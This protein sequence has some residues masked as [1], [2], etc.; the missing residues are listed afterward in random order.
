MGNWH[1][2]LGVRSMSMDLLRPAPSRPSLRGWAKLEEGWE[3]KAKKK[4]VTAKRQTRIKPGN[5]T[6]IPTPPPQPVCAG[7]PTGRDLQGGAAVS[8]SRQGRKKAT[9]R[10]KLSNRGLLLAGPILPSGKR[11]MQLEGKRKGM[12]RGGWHTLSPTERMGLSR[13]IVPPRCS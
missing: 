12:R 8:F 13:R 11:T 3:K 4:D 7:E 10:K 5:S 9:Q 2:E 1:S 6:P